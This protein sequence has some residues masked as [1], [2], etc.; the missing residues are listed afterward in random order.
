MPNITY[1]RLCECCSFEAVSQQSWSQHMKTRKHKRNSGEPICEPCKP[2]PIAEQQAQQ[3]AQQQAEQNNTIESLLAIIKTQSETIK[4][5]HDTIMRLQS[6]QVINQITQDPSNNIFQPNITFQ[7]ADMKHD[8]NVKQSQPIENEIDECVLNIDQVIDG[9]IKIGSVKHTHK[10]NIRSYFIERFLKLDAKERPIRYKNSCNKWQ[11]KLNNEWISGNNFDTK[12]DI[13]KM[14]EK[15]IVDEVC[16]YSRL[17]TEGDGDDTT[18]ESH[19]F[20]TK[21]M[22]E[23]IDLFGNYGLTEENCRVT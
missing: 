1:P 19:V 23:N 12:K 2:E 8:A 3:Q 11:Y 18:N 6:T 9:E 10:E 16:E 4:N 7:I 5:Q 14:I 22:I 17:I 20:L 13:N 21:F 15:K